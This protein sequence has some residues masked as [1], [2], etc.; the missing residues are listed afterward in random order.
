MFLKRTNLSVKEAKELEVSNANAVESFNRTELT[1]EAT[2]KE[3]KIETLI[4]ER[5]SL[6]Q[7]IAILR[8]IHVGKITEEEF[9]EY[10][11]YVEECIKQV[12]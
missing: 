5:Y 10:S 7:E 8:K 4:R 9:K 6:S 3:Y 1:K 12:G 2:E 11:D